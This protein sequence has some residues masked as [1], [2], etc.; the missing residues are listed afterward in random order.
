MRVSPAANGS[1]PKQDPIVSL[2]AG[3]LYHES[4]PNSRLEVIENCGQRPEVEKPDELVSL[5]KG[6][7]DG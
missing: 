4:I 2:S 7:L 5:V 6:F 1:L 3:Q